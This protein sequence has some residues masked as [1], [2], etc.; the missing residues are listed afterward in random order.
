LIEAVCS[1]VLRAAETREATAIHG[2]LNK[3]L[4]DARLAGARMRAAERNHGPYR[5]QGIA[6]K[7]LRRRTE[8]VEH[9][10]VC[11]VISRQF[12]EASKGSSEERAA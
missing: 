7:Q 12:A 11:E 1:L 3:S 6:A 8:R 9:Q 2:Q 4:P 5:D 10:A